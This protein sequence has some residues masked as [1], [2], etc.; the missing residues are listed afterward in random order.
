MPHLDH[1]RPLCA[2]FNGFLGRFAFF[3]TS[4]REDDLGGMETGEVAGGFE[5]ETDVG[6][7]HNDGL[8]GE[9]GLWNGETGYKLVVKEFGEETHV[10]GRVWI[11]LS[12]ARRYV[13]M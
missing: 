9:G 1:T 10:D 8:A 11:C 5:T 2:L 13:D 4:H 7:G 12:R 6:T 3:E